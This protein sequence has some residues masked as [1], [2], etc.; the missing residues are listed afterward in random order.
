ML[1][2][3]EWWKNEGAVQALWAFEGTKPGSR[4]PQQRFNHPPGLF[5]LP[6]NPPIFGSQSGLEPVTLRVPGQSSSDNGSS[7]IDID[8]FNFQSVA[9]MINNIWSTFE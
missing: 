1:S 9:R 2:L 8:K 3:R 4:E 6:R 7:L 5:L